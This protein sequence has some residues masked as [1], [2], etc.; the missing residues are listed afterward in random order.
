MSQADGNAVSSGA[1]APDDILVRARQRSSERSARAPRSAAVPHAVRR[2]AGA[3][4][5]RMLHR[6]RGGVCR[7]SE[8]GE[9]CNNKRLHLGDLLRVRGWLVRRTVAGTSSTASELQ[10]RERLCART[11]TAPICTLPITTGIHQCWSSAFHKM[12]R[13]MDG[14]STICPT[15]IRNRV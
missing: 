15:P 14:L 5:S 2:E 13:R 9:G 12:E 4:A 10:T 11:S 3:G 8:R 7:K 6:C 1:A